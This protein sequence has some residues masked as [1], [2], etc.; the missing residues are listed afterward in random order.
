MEQEKRDPE[1]ACLGL[2]TRLSKWRRAS[3]RIITLD[4]NYKLIG[5]LVDVEIRE[6]CFEQ[7]SIC[8]AK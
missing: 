6:S 2:D 7:V 4:G 8:R 5:G 3:E 1:L